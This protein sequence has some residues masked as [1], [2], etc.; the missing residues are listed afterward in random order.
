MSDTIIKLE[1]ISKQYRLGQV[2]TQ[3]LHGDFQRWW[4]RMQGK[5]D[6][7]L[8]IGQTNQL[9]HKSSIYNLQSDYVWALKDIN[10]EVKQGEILGNIGKNGAGK[11]TM[12]KMLSLIFPG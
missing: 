9:N 3:T 7:T 1:N 6:P 10:L 5:E 12:L 11:S 8:I 2:G 4:H